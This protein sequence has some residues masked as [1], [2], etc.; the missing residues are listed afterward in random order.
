MPEP[1]RF[2]SGHLAYSVQDLIGVCHQ[3]PQ[4]V[5]YYL[6]RGDFENW[7]NYLGETEIAKK[8]EEVRHLS[9]TEE[10]QLKQFIKVLQPPEPEET[11]PTSPPEMTTSESPAT[12]T[13]S[14]QDTSTQEVDNID[15]TDKNK[16]S[17]ESNPMTQLKDKTLETPEAKKP[18]ETPPSSQLKEP[19]TKE[20]K[21]EAKKPTETPPSSQLKEPTTKE[22]TTEAKK[23]TET[24]AQPKVTEKPKESKKPVVPVDE[25]S[26]EGPEA[27]SSFAKAFKDFI[28]QYISKE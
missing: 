23:P 17:E 9:V 27:R 10:E 1:F 18:T 8:V 14:N 15:S 4:E 13:P 5:I 3:S 7:L 21:T 19:T 20:T 24:P 6:K 28:S 11:T 2:S 22:T 26:D 12:I 25:S 16:E